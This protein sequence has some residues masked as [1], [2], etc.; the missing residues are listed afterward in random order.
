[1]HPFLIF[2]YIYLLIFSLSLMVNDFVHTYNLFSL[3]LVKVDFVHHSSL[4]PKVSMCMNKDILFK[5]NTAVSSGNLTLI[6]YFYVNIGCLPV[7]PIVKKISSVQSSPPLAGSLCSYWSCL[8]AVSSGA[9]LGVFFIMAFL[10]LE[11]VGHLFFKELIKVGLFD[12][13]C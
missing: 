11:N 2:C 9:F 5:I 8:Q 4:P 10:F 1:M 6:K 12:V 7:Q 13:S 3:E